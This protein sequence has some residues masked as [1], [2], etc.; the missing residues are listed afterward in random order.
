MSQ[1]KHL[2]LTHKQRLNAPTVGA[3]RCDYCEG[4]IRESVVLYGQEFGLKCTCEVCGNSWR[5]TDTD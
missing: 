3:E 2:T 4:F 1:F 5:A